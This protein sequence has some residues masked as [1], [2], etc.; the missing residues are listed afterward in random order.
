M[1]LGRPKESYRDEEVEPIFANSRG[2]YQPP[3]AGP[4]S[5]G[6]ARTVT[7]AQ[8]KDELNIF[9]GLPVRKVVLVSACGVLGLLWLLGV[10]SHEDPRPSRASAPAGRSPTQAARVTPAP[11]A[12][13]VPTAKPQR[14]RPDDEG[15]EG[16]EDE[17]MAR[18]RPGNHDDEEDG[19][20]GGEG[21]ASTH[22]PGSRAWTTASPNASSSA[23]VGGAASMGD[24]SEHD[25]GKGGG[26]LRGGAGTTTKPAKIGTTLPGAG[27]DVGGGAAVTTTPPAEGG[28]LSAPKA[29]PDVDNESGG[30]GPV[31]GAAVS[32]TARAKLSTPT[33]G[34]H[35]SVDG[36]TVAAELG[37]AVAS[38]T[39]MAELGAPLPDEGV[40]GASWHAQ[41]GAL[42]EDQGGG[43][44]SST[45]A[46]APAM[47]AAGTSTATSSAA[48][49]AD[50]ADTSTS[51]GSAAAAHAQDPATASNV[52]AVAVTTTAAP[53]A[54]GNGTA[55]AAGE[56]GRNG[57][58]PPKAGGGGA[59]RQKER[60]DEP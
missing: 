6:A 57:R 48:P 23:Q 11:A 50:E 7:F 41:G 9:Q 36:T 56:R 40:E 30:G 27:G 44:T 46:D 31:G 53:G 20:D 28:G 39:S 54:A 15:H 33:S 2:S 47:S 12:L 14:Q 43:S 60:N 21:D 3:G 38:T 13:R 52:T 55:D 1:K 17:P 45:H 49:D 19:G 4:A 26:G 22:G 59:A 51:S 25:E 24:H 34:E 18:A 16:A 58:K 8:Q 10:F 29:G 35:Q 42:G 32:T 37:T 5:S